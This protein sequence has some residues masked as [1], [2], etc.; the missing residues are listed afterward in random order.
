[1]PPSISGAAGRTEVLE[2]CERR[3]RVL[4]TDAGT[5]LETNS[6]NVQEVMVRCNSQFFEDES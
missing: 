1:M 6:E 4:Q 2:V 5:S 3:E